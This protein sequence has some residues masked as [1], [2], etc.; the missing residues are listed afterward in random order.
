MTLPGLNL[1]LAIEA[2]CYLKCRVAT[3]I[4]HWLKVQSRW[5]KNYVFVKKCIFISLWI[6]L[7]LHTLLFCHILLFGCLIFSLPSR[8][9]TIWIQIR[10]D[11]MSGLILVQTVCKSLQQT[12]KV[13]PAGKELNTKQL[14]DTTIW[15]KPWLKLISFDS[16]F[17]H[18]AKCWLQQILSQGKPCLTVA[19]S[20]GLILQIFLIMALSLHCRFVLVN[21]QVSLAWSMARHTRAVDMAKGLVREVVGCKNW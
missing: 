2:I 4:S 18:L 16:N 12:T 15:L 20:S 1:R 7:S 5:F 10:P 8:S 14:I 9:Q 21:G 11:I 17:F 6:L 13:A 3:N 19:I